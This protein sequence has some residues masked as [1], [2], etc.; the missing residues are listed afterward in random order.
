M[1]NFRDRGVAGMSNSAHTVEG[2]IPGLNQDIPGLELLL[3]PANLQ[4]TRQHL[5]VLELARAP[6]ITFLLT[7]R[8]SAISGEGAIMA[9]LF[10]LSPQLNNPEPA[11]PYFL[12][13]GGALESTEAKL[14]R[15]PLS[16]EV[17]PPE[18]RLD[19]P[20]LKLLLGLATSLLTSLCLLILDLGSGECNNI[21]FNQLAPFN[22]KGQG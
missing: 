16:L 20:G 21:L 3:E 13:V 11:N 22:I 5:L 7:N 2:Q 4:S 6:A 18:S 1:S 9:I 15:R 12:G 10:P 8:Y 19:I 14:C 17:G